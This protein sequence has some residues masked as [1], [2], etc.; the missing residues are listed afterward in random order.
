MRKIYVVALK[1]EER[2]SLEKLV[3]TGH[4]SAKR[5]THGRILLKADAGLA[6]PGWTDEQICTALDVSPITV[7]R[8]RKRFVEE[9][10]EVVTH[11]RKARRPSRCRLDG[12]QEARLLALA[13]SPA[14]EGHARWTL[15]LLAD[16]MV[17]LEYVEEISYETVRSVLKKT[18]LSPT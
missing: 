9:G 4:T 16:Q 6:G 8:V 10:L 17:I 3:S 7:A 13:C 18:S 11:R 2:A 5:Q 15:R 14:P 12:A 1:P